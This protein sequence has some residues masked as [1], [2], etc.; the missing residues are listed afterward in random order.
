MRG[1]MTTN[2]LIAYLLR[3]IRYELRYLIS[4]TIESNQ[5]GYQKLIKIYNDGD[6]E[7]IIK[8]TKKAVQNAER[9]VNSYHVHF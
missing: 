2:D 1:A 3:P 7:V 5:Y 9:L 8:P 6:S 4:I